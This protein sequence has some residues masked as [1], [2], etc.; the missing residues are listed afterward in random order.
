MTTMIAL[1]TQMKK[2]LQKIFL[3]ITVTLVAYG[4]SLRAS[5]DEVPTDI[6]SRLKGMSCEVFQ[7]AQGIPHVRPRDTQDPFAVYA[8]FG[9]LHGK[10]RAW[11]MDFFRRTAQGRT[12]E[13]LGRDQIRSDFLMRLLGLRELAERIYSTLPRVDQSRFWAYSEGVNRGFVEAQKQGSYELKALDY[14]L[15]P[16]RAEDSV[17]L[18]L[19]QSFDQTKRVFQHSMNEEKWHDVHAQ[20]AAEL[21]SNDGLPWDV[22]VLK[23]GEFPVKPSAAARDGGTRAPSGARAR[24]AIDAFP[25]LFGSAAGGGSNNWV[26]APTRTKSGRAWLAN[27]PHLSLKHPPFW[28][29]GHVTGYDVSGKLLDVIGASLPG[30]PVVVS[31]ANT[32]AAWGLTNAFLPAARVFYVPQAEL[33]NVPSV[34][35]WIWVRFWKIK[36]PFFFKTFQRTKTGLPV[37]P[38]SAPDGRA[39][40]LQWSGYDLQGSDLSAL[41]ELGLAQSA[42]GVDRALAKVGVPTWNFVF[43]DTQ[44]TVGYR[45]VGRVFKL[46]ESPFFGVPRE[47]LMKV[48]QKGENAGQNAVLSALEMPHVFNP[49]R[50]YIVTA[51]NRQ[52][53]AQASLNPGRGPCLGFRAFRIEELLT[54]TA[55][56]TLETQREI[57]CDVQA[58]DARFLAPMLLRVLRESSLDSKQIKGFKLIEG[59]NFEA[60]LNCRACGLYRR[61]VNEILSAQHLNETALYRKLTAGADVELKK[62]VFESFALVLNELQGNGDGLLPKW[63]DLHRNYFR[64]LAGEG[65]FSAAPISTP[66]DDFSVNPGTSDWQAGE[67]RHKEGASQRMLVELSNPPT[68]YSV[69]AGSNRDVDARDLAGVDGPWQKWAQCGLEQRVFPLSWTKIRGELVKF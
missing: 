11:Q 39:L 43:A 37:L 57:Q 14:G 21:F 31:G 36:F 60:N 69:L 5:G 26:L 40:V 17:M 27:D 64:H 22:S 50:G 53:P 10:D 63:G 42:S 62:T 29:W 55:R 48:E 54:K 61:W 12:A 15:E 34:R 4:A 7:D 20:G 19:L 2:R 47:R 35:P 52:W 6:A 51:N 58:V 45:S 65:W 68:V 44:G 9:Y 32:S 67:F 28:Y 18:I 8:C 3:I 1:K 24:S 16:W 33:D 41:F 59:W 66:G 30:V 13:V 23:P 46:E 25:D 38:L 56:H 49:K